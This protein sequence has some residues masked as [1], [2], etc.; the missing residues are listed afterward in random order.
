M[1]NTFVVGPE[2]IRGQARVLERRLYPWVARYRSV[3]PLRCRSG[4]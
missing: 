3:A 4:R 2:F 1:K